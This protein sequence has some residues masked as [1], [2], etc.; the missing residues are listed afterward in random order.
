VVPEPVK[1]E[2]EQEAVMVRG[3]REPTKV[4]PEADSVSGR[5]GSSG[6]AR[7]A[8]GAGVGGRKSALGE[9]RGGARGAEGVRRSAR[10]RPR[11]RRDG[12]SM[13]AALGFGAG[14][15]KKGEGWAEWLLV[16]GGVGE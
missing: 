6:E 8:S 4:V 13:L 9:R 1:D 2:S 7:R 3:E 12:R 14:G 11:A 16:I 15:G 10:A 5:E